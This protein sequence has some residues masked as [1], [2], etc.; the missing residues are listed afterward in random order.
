MT[1][2]HKAVPYKQLLFVD[3][4]CLV[5]QEDI[6]AFDLLYEKVNHCPHDSVLAFPSYER[7]KSGHRV[8]LTKGA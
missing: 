8:T 3:S 7:Q 6:C 4:I 1:S 5:E 2:N